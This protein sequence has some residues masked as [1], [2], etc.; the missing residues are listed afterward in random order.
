MEV[1][2]VEKL[3]SLVPLGVVASLI[4]LLVRFLYKTIKIIIEK[5]Y[6]EMIRH[7]KKTEEMLSKIDVR[8]SIVERDTYEMRAQLLVE[9]NLA[10]NN[11]DKDLSEMRERVAKIEGMVSA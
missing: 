6:D 7:N 1:S 9:K 11:I 4:V 2:H 10:Q 3:L 8:L 5:T